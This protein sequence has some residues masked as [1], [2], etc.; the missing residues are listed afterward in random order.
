MFSNRNRS[1]LCLFAAALLFLLIGLLQRRYEF[2]T[3]GIPAGLPSPITHSGASLGINVYLEQYDDAALAENLAQI[4]Q[5]GITTIKQSFYFDE[6]FDWAASDRLVSAATNHNLQLVPLLDGNPADDFTP[7]ADPATFAAWA[8]EFAGRYADQLTYYI[9]WDE[10]NLGNHWGNQPV[11]PAGYAALLTAAAQ[12]VRAADPAAVIV[13]APLAPTI[14][15]GTVNLADAIYLEGLYQVGAAPAFDVVA[16]KPYGFDSNPADR[17]VDFQTL[18]FSRVTLLREVMERF[19]DSSKAIWAGNWGWNSLP[20][21]WQGAPS[22]WGQVD[23]NTQVEWTVAALERARQEWPWMGLMFL[24]NWQPAAPPDDPHWGFSIAGNALEPG[25]TEFLAGD[26]I[27]WPG[28]HLARPDDP[29]QVYT[30]SWRFSP[31]FGADIGASGDRV[32][33]RFFGTDVGVRVR[34]ADY[35]GRFYATIDGQPANALPTDERGAAL[36]LTS[37]EPGGDNLEIVP[38]ATGLEPGDHTLELVA[39]EGVSQWSLNGFSVAYHQPAGNRHRNVIAGLWLGVFVLLGMAVYYGRLAEWGS[40][41]QRVSAA[42][43]R[44]EQQVQVALTILAAV[45][46]ALTGWLT[47]GEQAAG[48][49]RR[50]GDG[51]QLAATVSAA[52]VF[53]IAPSFLLYL[54]ALLLLFTLI[55]FRPVWGLALVAFSF[56]FYVNPNFTF[57]IR[58]KPILGYRFSPVEMYLL[59]TLG[60]FV[61]SRIAYSVLRI[62][63]EGIRNTLYAIRYTFRPADL[64][65]LAFTLVA[66]LSLLFTERLD[67]ASNEWRIVVVEPFLFYLLLRA[68]R[69]SQK[70]LWTVL[71]AFVLGGVVIALVGLWQY[72]AWRTDLLITSEGGLMR[73]RSIYGSPNNVALYLGRILPLTIT[74]TLMGQGR[75]RWAYALAMALIGPAILLSFSKGGLF[76]GVPA[77]LFVILVYWQRTAGR[78]VWPWLVGAAVAGVLALLIALQIPQLAGRLDPRGATGVLRLNLWQSSLNMI[79]DHPIFGVGL[80]NFL[81]AYRGRYIFDAAWQ[82]P[83]LSHPHNIL[84]DFATRLGL[85]GLVTGMWLF[86]TFWR[87]AAPL[88]QRVAA[89]W[90]PVAI[91]L[92][93]AFAHMLAHS[94]VD[95]S[96][97]LVDLAYAF[98]LM[99]GTAVWLQANQP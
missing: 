95:Q 18:N 6:P 10:P 67:V 81:Y 28:Y 48:L 70:E 42:F 50:L 68:M 72:A 57:L 52:A 53:Y 15:I 37:A 82:E 60:A 94:L 35:H 16:A 71:D 23:S 86:W 11:S 87:T 40:L 61:L 62:K 38:I 88:P 92:L 19:G 24:E 17:T 93:A 49:Y 3:R 76:L 22:I 97:F 83:N 27:A 69:L 79:R 20:A 25:L 66:T 33:V 85:A 36:V 14:E 59:V 63:N 29:T 75:R 56:P 32:T 84:L 51:S 7:P 80:D 41:G 55:Y 91:G 96:F 58:P 13:A 12:A 78:P 74:V 47:W 43:N 39:E 89:E 54:P 31:E 45:L 4:Q 90:R 99:L 1:L 30:G 98:Y 77:A 44:L 46:V 5:T 64:A 21:D 65:A 73:L 8:S 2:L 9:I 26:S 34:K